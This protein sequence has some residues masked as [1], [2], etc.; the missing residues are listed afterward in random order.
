VKT[1][2][3]DQRISASITNSNTNTFYRLLNKIWSRLIINQSKENKLSVKLNPLPAFVFGVEPNPLKYS[4]IL[5]N[6]NKKKCETDFQSIGDCL[7]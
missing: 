7:V 3:K 2:S 4:Q 1:N 6:C 5:R